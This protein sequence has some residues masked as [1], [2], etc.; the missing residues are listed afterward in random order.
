VIGRPSLA[1][2]LRVAGVRVL[3]GMLPVPQ[4]ALWRRLDPEGRQ[5]EA[6]DRY[7][8]AALRVAPGSAPRFQAL[9]PTAFAV[10]FDP[11]SPAL[12]ELGA[13]HLLLDGQD[14]APFGPASGFEEVGRVGS[15]RLYRINAAP[16]PARAARGSAN[17]RGTR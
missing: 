14:P 7:G 12:R 2:L 10:S 13:T 17:P 15:A 8:I 16:A 9:R 6:Y 4:P 3:N 5:S 1:E 11:A